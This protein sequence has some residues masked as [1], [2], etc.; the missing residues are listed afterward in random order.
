MGEAPYLLKCELTPFIL[1]T[2]SSN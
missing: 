2:L 1:H